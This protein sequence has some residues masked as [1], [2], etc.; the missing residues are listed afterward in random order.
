MMDGGH[1]R[2]K[3]PV[4]AGLAGPYGHPFHP[5]LVTIPI[6]AWVSSF[7]FDIVAHVGSRPA[8]AAFAALWLL[9]IG[10]VGALAAASVGFLDL[11]RLPPHTPARRT[12]A[13]HATL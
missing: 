9:P 1:E 10:V 3:R 5:I 2:S 8:G 4:S 12:A 6:G 13:L 11:L 7:L